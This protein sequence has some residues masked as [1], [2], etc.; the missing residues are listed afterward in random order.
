MNPLFFN[1]QIADCTMG[2]LKSLRHRAKRSDMKRQEFA[3]LAT[4]LFSGKFDD[5]QFLNTLCKGLGFDTVT[6]FLNF[7]NLDREKVNVG[8]PRT[9]ITICQKLYDHW[10]SESDLSN[11]RR[12]S[13]HMVKVKKAKLN[14]NIMD[15]V[16]KDANVSINRKSMLLR[17]TYRIPDWQI[18]TTHC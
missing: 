6:E 2:Q 5:R 17:S 12:N 18:S 13:R 9:D 3:K 7:V 4:L 16:E 10:I 14:D 8:R 1:L 15:L 11:D